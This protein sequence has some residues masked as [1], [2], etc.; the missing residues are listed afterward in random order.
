MR[1]LDYDKSQFT[2]GLLKSRQYAGDLVALPE[3]LVSVLLLVFIF[4]VITSILVNEARNFWT[5][6]FVLN[7]SELAV[8]VS[9]VLIFIRKLVDGLGRKLASFEADPS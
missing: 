8:M 7:P 3:R 1:E 2:I 6:L 9:L 5:G 4:I